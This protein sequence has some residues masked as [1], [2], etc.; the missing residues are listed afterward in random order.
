MFP[1]FRT[2]KPVTL[3]EIV[4]IKG[5]EKTSFNSITDPSVSVCMNSSGPVSNLNC[6]TPYCKC[7]NEA[8]ELMPKEPEPFDEELIKLKKATNECDLIR[9]KLGESWLG[10]NLSDP[11]DPSNCNC[12]KSGPDYWKYQAYTTT[13]STFWKTDPKTPILRNAQMMLLAYQRIVITVH[14][15]K[16]TR[17]GDL[18]EIDVRN[19]ENEITKRKRFNGKWMVYRTER[20]IE[21]NRCTMSLYLMRD[22]NYLEP[23]KIGGLIKLDK[24]K[25]YNG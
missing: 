25:K 19:D 21:H 17:P 7:S 15:D 4:E 16:D 3:D 14:G 24:E 9:Q 22:S 2:S 11:N 12:P 18:I 20:R 13:N 6:S 5:L 10:C 1:E 8:L 23:V